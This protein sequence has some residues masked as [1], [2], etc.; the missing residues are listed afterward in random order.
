MI[1]WTHPSFPFLRFQYQ[2]AEVRWSDVIYEL[3]ESW[4]LWLSEWAPE[5]VAEAKASIITDP[6]PSRPGDPPHTRGLPGHN[7]RDA[8]T[9]EY[10]HESPGVF[11]FADAKIF[12]S[13]QM[14]GPIGSLM[15]YG[16]FFRGKRYP[17]RPILEPVIEH[18]LGRFHPKSIGGGFAAAAKPFLT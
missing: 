15:E 5:I 11:G 2:Q 4:T 1:T 18:Q 12:I 8:I 7:I 13:E 16:G 3:Q 10:D 9:W 17:P 6:K 14:V